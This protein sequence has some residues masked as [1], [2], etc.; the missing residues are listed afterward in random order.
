LLYAFITNDFSVKYVANNSIGAIDIDGLKTIVL[1]PGHGDKYNR[2]NSIDPGAIAN[3][4]EEKDLALMFAKRLRYYLKLMGNTVY[5][6]RTADKQERVTKLKW[7]VDYSKS[8][9][10]DLFVS[11]HL[12]FGPSYRKGGAVYYYRTSKK[13]K[14]HARNISNWTNAQ[15]LSPKPAGFY[16]THHTVAPAVLIELGFI[17]NM[18]DIRKVQDYY[19]ASN[20]AGAITGSLWD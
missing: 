6:T 11:L 13:G 20:L 17:S 10:P 9:K 3:G 16:V 5:M 14:K 4:Y 15:N 18:S 12:D 19:Y 8:K 1:D 7:R 2:W